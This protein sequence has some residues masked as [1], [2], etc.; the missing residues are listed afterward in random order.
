M[1]WVQSIGLG[2]AQAIVFILGFSRT[3][4]MITGGLLVGLTHEDAVRYSFFL[5]TPIIFAAALLKIPVLFTGLE[6]FIG[7][8]VIDSIFAGIFAYISVKFLT[9]YFKVHTLTLF[10][11]YCVCAGILVSVFFLFR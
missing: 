10:A 7:P 9:M 4:A 8:A 11:V 3:G 6:Q 2:A 5:A 1:K